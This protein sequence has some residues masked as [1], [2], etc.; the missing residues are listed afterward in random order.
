MPVHENFKL[1]LIIHA[2][3]CFLNMHAQLSSGERDPIVGLRLHLPP[4]IRCV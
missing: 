1:V 3:S 4:Y 2:L